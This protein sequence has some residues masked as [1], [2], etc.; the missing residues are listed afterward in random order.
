MSRSRFVRSLIPVLSIALLSVVPI[1]AS[2]QTKSDVDRAERGLEQAQEQKAAAYRRYIA[3]QNDL[4]V[5]VS[6]YEEINEQ[7]EDLTYRIAQLYDR[8]T[9]YETEAGDLR[10]QARELVLEAYTSGGTGLMTVAFEAGS[11]QDLLTSQVLIDRA[12]TRD[13]ADLD[14]LD[15]VRRDMDRQRAELADKEAEVKVLEEEANA[16]VEQMAE[17]FDAAEHAYQDASAAERKAIDKL[18]KEKAEFKAAEAR[19]K[20]QQA[21]RARMNASGAAAGLP[22]EATPGFKCPVQ[23][24]TSF[25]NSWGF[26]RSGGRKHKGTDMFAARGTPVQAVVDGTVKFRTVN[27]GGTVAYVYGDDGNKYYYAHLDGYVSGIADGQRVRAGTAIGYVGNSGNARYTSP[28]L[29]FEIRVDRTKSVNPYP[30][31][32][33]YCP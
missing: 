17:L 8:I 2:A 29:H 27:L 21:A 19:R 11:I 4:E 7:L 6:R 31:V 23:G 28:H 15:A 33:Y 18:R 9:A 13:L 30:T 1:G 22:P 12:T 3:A 25:I 32:R 5:A 14:R 26:P 10:D 24:R 20:A 16:L